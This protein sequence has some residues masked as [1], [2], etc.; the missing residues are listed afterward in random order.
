M[1]LVASARLSTRPRGRN[2]KVSES[3]SRGFDIRRRSRD[4]RRG[5]TRRLGVDRRGERHTE[6]VVVPPRKRGQARCRDP[7][8]QHALQPGQPERP[9]RPRAD[10]RAE[11]LHHRPRH[12]ALEHAY[13]ADR[14]HGRRLADGVYGPVRRSARS[15]L[16]EQLRDLPEQ[17][18]G[19]LE[20]V[21]RVLDEHVR[22]RPVP[23][24]ALLA[25]GASRGLAALDAAGAVGAVHAFGV[26]CRRCLDGQ[27][28][29]REHESRPGELLRSELPGGAAA[30]RGHRFVQAAGDERLRRC[31]RPLRPGRLVLRGCG[32]GQVRP[33]DALA[34]RGH[35]SAPR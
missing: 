29:A 19:R 33:V 10:A 11:E 12:A 6:R 23:E 26:Q 15:R 7:L 31:R 32:G 35:G 4:F 25:Q 3:H 18:L 8:R 21:V 30:Q 9:L 27:H 24:H 17:R 16:D 2:E 28:G 13:A 22:H 20:V 34:Y 1:E 5:N 14:A